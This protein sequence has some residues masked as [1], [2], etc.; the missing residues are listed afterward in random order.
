MY[1]SG[2]P[3]PQCNFLP[4]HACH[5]NVICKQ[6]NIAL[7]SFLS[8]L[9]LSKEHQLF[10]LFLDAL[11]L[12]LITLEIP[13]T[14]ESWSFL[15]ILLSPEFKVIYNQFILEESAL[16]EHIAS[17]QTLILSSSCFKLIQSCLFSLL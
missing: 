4:E 17:S 16:E 10:W 11:G 14:L 6:V 3:D 7:N 12:L 8:H 13:K 1:Y 9:R 2:N 5:K 15:Y